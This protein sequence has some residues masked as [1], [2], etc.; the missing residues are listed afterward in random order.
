[1]PPDTWTILK[2]LEWAT[3]HFRTHHIDQPR[4]DAEILLSHALSL[5]RVDLY[6][7][8]DRPLEK[9]EL[10]AFKELVKRRL[11]REPVAYI[12]GEKGFWTLDL[13]LTRDVLIPRPETE[14]IVEAA[15]EVLPFEASQSP[16][17]VLDLGTG[18]GAIVLALARERPGHRF[19]GVDCSYGALRVAKRNA[20]KYG[21]HASVAFFQ[22][23][24]CDAL[25]HVERCFDVIVSNPPYVRR[26]EL[27]TLSPEIFR[28]EPLQALD[29]GPDGLNAIR[30]IIGQAAS[31]LTPGGWLMMEIGHD[32]GEAVQRLFSASVAYDHVSVTKDY[33]GL[34]RLVRARATT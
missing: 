25:R 21:L 22:G 17:H 10:G 18:S 2:V 9:D 4:S 30:V 19:Y 8:Y 1:M 13:H 24:W 11:Q 27:K 28:F 34:D 15:L 29:G 31:C 14:L 6:L 32:Q 33:S 16:F 23:R 5:T 20:E 3:R 26:D 7:Q 12:V